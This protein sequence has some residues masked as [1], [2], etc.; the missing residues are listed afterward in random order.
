M[1]RLALV[2]RLGLL[3]TPPD[4]RFDVFTRLAASVTGAPVSTISLI[5]E[6]RVW[7]KSA[8]GLP[9][10]VAEVPR[11]IAACA[12][13]I[14]AADHVLVIPDATRDPRV[15]GSPLV[16]GEFGMRF[17]AGAPL[18]APGGEVL[19]ALCVID[20]VPREPSPAMIRALEDL[21]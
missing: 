10:G 20:R 13:V 9:E 21:A 11:D 14:D 16:T 15:S 3:D 18:R 12:H 4:E 17:Y 5:D 6:A 19:G 2:R 7:F 1:R 8:R